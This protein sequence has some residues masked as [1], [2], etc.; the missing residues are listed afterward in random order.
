MMMVKPDLNKI[1]YHRPQEEQTRFVIVS[2][3]V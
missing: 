1:H 2:K 3:F